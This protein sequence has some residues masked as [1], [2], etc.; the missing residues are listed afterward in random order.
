MKKQIRGNTSASSASG[1][2]FSRSIGKD[3]FV[4]L[5]WALWR[6]IQCSINHW[7]TRATFCFP[8]I[9]KKKKRTI[10]STDR[11]EGS[12]SHKDFL[13]QLHCSYIQSP[14]KSITG[15]WLPAFQN[16]FLWT[17]NR[18]LVGWNGWTE[19]VKNTTSHTLLPPSVERESED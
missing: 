8:G 3:I 6:V 18:S 17:S 2:W 7:R 19:T 4:C 9:T 11:A 10:W 12:T 16:D 13:R 1:C 5:Q 15:N 14:L